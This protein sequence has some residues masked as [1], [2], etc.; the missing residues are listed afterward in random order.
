MITVKITKKQFEFYLEKAREKIR[1]EG[2]AEQGRNAEL[3]SNNFACSFATENEFV[4]ILRKNFVTSKARGYNYVGNVSNAPEDIIVWMNKEEK[5]IDIKSTKLE[6]FQRFQKM[7]Y[8]C[9]QFYNN[10]IP[11]ILIFCSIDIQSEF[12]IINYYGFYMKEELIEKLKNHSEKRYSLK[13]QEHFFTINYPNND[14][15]DLIKQL[16][17]VG[18]QQPLEI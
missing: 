13:N 16:D 7:C 4:K 17:K 15:M 8:P 11:D 12:V 10:Q 18:N 3:K 1:I 5:E 9:D 14:T 2:W 6:T